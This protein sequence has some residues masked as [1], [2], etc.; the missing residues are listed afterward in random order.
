MH[1][2]VTFGFQVSK[3]FNI[4]NDQFLNKERIKAKKI[5][6]RDKQK[7]VN[8]SSETAHSPN[9]INIGD[10][11][12]E[13]HVEYEFLSGYKFKLDCRCWE[14]AVKIYTENGDWCLRPILCPLNEDLIWIVFSVHH[15]VQL[16]EVQLQHFFNYII[17]YRIFHGKKQFSERAKKDKVKEFYINDSSMSTGPYDFLEIYSF[18]LHNSNFIR[19]SSLP[20]SITVTNKV[21]GDFSIITYL[22]MIPDKVHE[23]KFR[24]MLR[25]D[26]FPLESLEVELLNVDQR[27]DMKSVPKKRLKANKLNKRNYEKEVAH[28]IHLP[29]ETVFSGMGTT[30]SFKR[31]PQSPNVSSVFISTECRNIFSDKQLLKDLNPIAI[32]LEQLSNFPAELIIENGFKYLY[33][34][35]PFLN[36]TIITPYYTPNRTMYFEFIKCFLC[37]EI[38]PE[39]LINFLTT[40]FLI[41]EIIGIRIV[42]VPQS[43]IPISKKS[44]KDASTIKKSKITEVT[45]K[46]EV[47]LGVAK[48][49]VSDLLRGFW[50]I[51]LISSLSHP[52]N[53]DFT[54]TN[55]NG[56]E[57]INSPLTNDI[58]TSLGTSVKIK[59]RLSYDLRKIQQR[60]LRSKDILNRIFFILS[61][62]K[63]VNDILKNVSSHNSGLLKTYRYSNQNA[64]NSKVR[65]VPKDILTGFVINCSKTFYIFLEG[66][67]MRILYP[68]VELFILN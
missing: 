54:R 55:I 28:E 41:V 53:T 56:D 44:N 65:D 15:L 57:M 29:A 1:F 2:I 13:I 61:D 52:C 43:S 37:K 67:F 17:T 11:L 63:L 12:T 8:N 7:K 25:K 50:E 16:N 35:I 58:L 19:K 10:V 49:D 68:L 32:K 26:R 48:F 40:K 20:A 30:T 22:D 6:R 62:T 39:E 4:K 45:T 5:N 31:T 46:E 64:E 33:V 18:D 21:H 24:K 59:V 3:K 14:T 36:H 60:I 38:S 47:L 66:G 27:S 42:N 23:Y 51:R 34:K 9:I